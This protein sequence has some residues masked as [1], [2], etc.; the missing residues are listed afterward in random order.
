MPIR[1]RIYSRLLAAVRLDSAAG[2]ATRAA[3][4]PYPG[5][6]IVIDRRSTAS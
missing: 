6:K 5:L 1:S 4:D 3:G 2:A